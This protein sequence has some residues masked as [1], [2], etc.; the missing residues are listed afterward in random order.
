[1]GWWLVR[2]GWALCAVVL[3]WLVLFSGIDPGSRILFALAIPSVA[4]AFLCVGYAVDVRDLRGRLVWL[5]RGLALV[6][7]AFAISF[8]GQLFQE[9]LTLQSRGQT[10]ADWYPRAVWYSAATMPLV[11]IPALVALRWPR[12]GGTLFVLGGIFNVLGSIYHPFGVIFPE[13]TTDPVA[14]TVFAFLPGFI[15]A[16][17]LLIGSTSTAGEH[18]VR[19]STHWPALGYCPPTSP[20]GRAGA[21][22]RRAASAGE[23]P[24]WS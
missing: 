22:S 5:G 17:L 20:G 4:V 19:T 1:V 12:L 10:P 11:L 14:L 6:G 16:A 8:P 24:A 23:C 13:T 18:R 15:T 9:V 2:G 7:A 3:A 21:R